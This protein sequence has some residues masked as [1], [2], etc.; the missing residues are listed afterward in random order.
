MLLAFDLFAILNITHPLTLTLSLPCANIIKFFKPCSLRLKLNS[1]F[2]CKYGQISYVPF[3]GL[4]FLSAWE[5][6]RAFLIVN[7]LYV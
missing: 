7:S 5:F 6:T 4:Y 3:G 1:Y 2:K